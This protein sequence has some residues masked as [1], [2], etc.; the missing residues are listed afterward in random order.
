ME[1]NVKID[2][3][4]IKIKEIRSEVRILN[5]EE[6]AAQEPIVP[7]I[8]EPVDEK[9]VETLKKE[10]INKKDLDPD[11]IK[12]IN[13][14][15]EHQKKYIGVDVDA[16]NKKMLQGLGTKEKVDVILNGNEGERQSVSIASTTSTASDVYIDKR[17]GNKLHK[18]TNK[19][20]DAIWQA[21]LE[22][23]VKDFKRIMGYGKE[24]IK[25]VGIKKFIDAMDWVD[26]HD[27]SKYKTDTMHVVPCPACHSE[28]GVYE[29]NIGL[30]FKCKNNYDMN[31]FWDTYRAVVKTD[32]QE[33]DS[34]IKTFFAFADFRD[35]YRIK[36]PAEKVKDMIAEKFGDV[37]TFRFIL[38]AISIAAAEKLSKDEFHK[39]LK[40]SILEYIHKKEDKEAYISFV[41]NLF[42]GVED[43]GWQTTIIIKLYDMLHKK[44]KL[45]KY[46]DVKE[47]N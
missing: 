36:T 6:Q 13:L 17:T 25:R 38:D 27:I 1:D 30:C 20:Y 9:G 19:Q 18:R 22:K 35:K 21:F 10:L 39:I 45:G 14:P 40:E 3:R 41:D 2:G 31:R 4:E 8:E 29:E 16:A 32:P 33:A 26:I 46:K 28:F 47:Q 12:K 37:E 42:D 5:N 34:M 44:H 15:P 23:E 11:N 7:Q 43:D 24:T